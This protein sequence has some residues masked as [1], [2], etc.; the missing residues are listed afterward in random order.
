MINV[1][2]CIPR[3]MRV[4]CI[5]T[6]ENAIVRFLVLHAKPQPVFQFSIFIVRAHNSFVNDNKRYE[7]D[8][9]TLA[10]KVQHTTTLSL[11]LLLPI[12]GVYCNWD[13]FFIL[14]FIIEKTDTNNESKNMPRSEHDECDACLGS[15]RLNC[16]VYMKLAVN[17][18]PD[19]LPRTTEE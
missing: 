5:S 14:F 10:N 2:L 16:I 3:R 4:E 19:S 12:A 15:C 11:L 9:W 1:P 8:R 17:S 7:H 18:R 6:M 13:F